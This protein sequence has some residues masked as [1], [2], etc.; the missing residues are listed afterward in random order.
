MLPLFLLYASINYINCT[1]LFVYVQTQGPQE[2]TGRMDYRVVIL[3][4]KFFQHNLC[5][6][7]RHTPLPFVIS[8]PPISGFFFKSIPHAG[9]I[10]S[11][12]LPNH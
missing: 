4:K 10:Y 2:A 9:S 12:V 1:Y 7:N 3:C 6:V 5:T 8:P 11:F